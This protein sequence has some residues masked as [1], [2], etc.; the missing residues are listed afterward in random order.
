VLEGDPRAIARAISLIEN[1]DP[2]SVELV[3]EIFRH[4][5]RA[6]LIG[7]TGPP[8]G[9]K[10]TLAE[11]IADE[12]GK[13]GHGAVCLPA[14][15][16]DGVDSYD[17]VVVGSAVYM[18]RWRSG[19]RRFL[20]R[21]ARALALRP[22]W[23]FSSGPVG[24]PARDNPAWAEPG[25]TMRRVEHLGARQHVVFAGRVPADPQGPVA[26]RMAEDTPPEFRDRRDWDT[27][28]AWAD[29]IASQL[30]AAA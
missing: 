22:L 9:G 26:R 7:V 8:G 5:G 24:D 30:R 29:G 2:A 11:A 14:E 10:S 28:R 15:Q 21:H 17:G 25:R 4:T 18:K 6:Y 13:H 16:V 23:V 20:R 27:I 19:A 1:E 12:L 3:R